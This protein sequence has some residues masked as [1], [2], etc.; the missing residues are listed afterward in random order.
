MA[1]VHNRNLEPQ[2]FGMDDFQIECLWL[3][4]LRFDERLITCRFWRQDFLAVDQNF[5]LNPMGMTRRKPIPT[6]AREKW[7]VIYRKSFTK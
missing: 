6:A 3:A 7:Q 1:T 4:A 5:D 2:R